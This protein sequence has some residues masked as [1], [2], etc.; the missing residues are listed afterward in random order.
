MVASRPAD[1]PALPPFEG[2]DDGARLRWAAIVGAVAAVAAVAMFVL[3]RQLGRNEVAGG[4]ATEAAFVDDSPFGR[5]QPVP[6]TGPPPTPGTR[7]VADARMG[8]LAGLEFVPPAGVEP[9]QAAVVLR[10]ELDDR[11]IGAWFAGLA[12]HDVLEMEPAGSSVVLSAGPR[13]AEADPDTASILNRAMAG[14]DRIDLRR[15]DP[16]FSAAWTSAGRAIERWVRTEGVFRRR[17]PHAGGFKVTANLGLVVFGAFFVLPILGGLSEAAGANPTAEVV[18]AVAIAVLTPVL[19]GWLAY[20]R[21]TRS[22]GARGSAIALRSESFRRFL[23][24][25]EAQH[26]EWAWQNGLLR[27]YSAWAVALGEADAWNHALS[28]SAVP[29]PEVAQTHGIMAP[30]LYSAAFH[31]ARTAPSQSGGGGGFSGGGFSGGGSVG[32]G[33]G[34]GGGGSW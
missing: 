20:G 33:G 5:S 6:G 14:R 25:S 12:A 34:G 13:A 9:W 11:T 26:V 16:S 1:L 19:A 24:A 18:G 7:M 30:V 4:G 17:P 23:H 8:E 15:W 21:L 27:D 32:G 10:E 22:L 31:S 3:C 29:A 2:R 28:A